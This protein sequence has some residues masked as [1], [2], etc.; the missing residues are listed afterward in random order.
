MYIINI[1]GNTLNIERNFDV[2]EFE[3]LLDLGQ[4]EKKA[5]TQ[6]KKI[7]L[8]D[9]EDKIYIKDIDLVITSESINILAK[10]SLYYSK[11][12]KGGRPKNDYPTNWE[13]N[14]ILYKAKKINWEVFAKRVGLKKSTFYNFLNQYEKE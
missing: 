10:I 6:L 7:F 3:S 11:W 5:I 12:A 13:E 9:K 8:V 14:Y 1:I 4:S 2:L